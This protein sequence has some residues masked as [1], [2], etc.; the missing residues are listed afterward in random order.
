ME[1]I[2]GIAAFAKEKNIDLVFVAP[3][4][5]L[6]AGMVDALEQAGI[7]AFGPR[8]NAAVIE[9]SKVFSK[10]LMKKYG[11]PTAGYEVFSEPKK[12]ID[13]IT[14]Q[15]KFP[16][17]VK[18]DGLALGKEWSSARIWKRQ[19]RRS[20]LLWKTKFLELPATRS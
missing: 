20:T 19:K 5:P 2:D 10:N 7:R 3:D 16:V 11:I 14:A 4:D 13:Y 9:S 15:N 12:A 1:D 6:A 18:A 17:V 8:K